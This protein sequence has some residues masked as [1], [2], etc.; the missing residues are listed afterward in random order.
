MNSVESWKWFG[1]AKVGMFFHFGLYSLLGGNE[2]Q[3]RASADKSEYRKLLGKFKAKRFDADEWVECAASMGARYIVPTAKH[4]EGFCLWDSKLTRYKSTNTP[5]SRDIMAEL[6]E[7]CS[8][9][10]IKFAF[11]FNLETWLNENDDIWNEKGMSYPDFIEGQLTELLT[12]YGQVSLIWFDHSHE[13]LPRERIVRIY[14]LIKKLQPDCLVNNRGVGKKD[15][16]VGDFLTP[17]RMIPES[18][19]AHKLM[20]EC[21]DAMGVRSW[22]Y[23]NQEAFWS[24]PELARRVSNCSSK[25]YN[26]LLNVEPAPDGSIR[27]ECRIRARKLGSWIAQNRTALMG[28]PSPVKP[29]DVNVLGRPH[30]GL[31]TAS[32]N[33]LHVHLHEWPVSDEILLPVCGKLRKNKF[34]GA[35][36]EDGLVIRGLPPVPPVGHGPWI[37]SIDFEKMPVAVD[38]NKEKILEPDAAGTVFLSPVDA[39]RESENGVLFQNLNHFPDGSVSMGSLHRINDLLSWNVVIPETQEYEA[40][41]AFGSIKCQDNAGFE[42]S[43]GTSSLKGRTW[44]TEH[45]SQPVR[46]PV[47]RIFLKKGKNRLTLRVTDV[48]NGS[49]SDVHGIWLVPVAGNC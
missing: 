19:S 46:K 36:T 26:Y 48:P 31:C 38:C 10:E 8:R 43:N 25:G 42:L 30:I 16:P 15:L 35:E 33:T 27:P 9:T 7:A 12:G 5:C 29:V 11:Y 18:D 47:G 44:L 13:E 3:V 28:D 1:E 41:A 6:A 21:C 22:G 24:V 17:E 45:Y 34:K 14:N 40:H 23:Y 2:N 32:G 49:F 37:I 39:G 20:I 4:A